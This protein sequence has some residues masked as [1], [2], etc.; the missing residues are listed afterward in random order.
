M[1]VIA[2]EGVIFVTEKALAKAHELDHSN[3]ELP[4]F[5]RS[6]SISGDL[7]NIYHRI[8]R[9]YRLNEYLQEE[10]PFETDIRRNGMRVTES[11]EV[12]KLALEINGV[13]TISRGKQAEAIKTTRNW[14]LNTEK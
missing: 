1:R 9:E 2:C 10:S 4:L 6:D 3:S 14:N 13:F 8:I 5:R 7:F 11:E 12:G